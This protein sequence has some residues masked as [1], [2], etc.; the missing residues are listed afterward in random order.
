M[1][2]AGG[3]AVCI[4]LLHSLTACGMALALGLALLAAANPPARA[5]LQRLGAINI[6][7]VFLC[8]SRP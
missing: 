3:L 2:F 8:A 7:I 1:A 4:S 6:F 5:L